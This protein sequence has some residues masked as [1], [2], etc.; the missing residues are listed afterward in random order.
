M[1][2]PVVVSL[3]FDEF[4]EQVRVDA[5]P[6]LTAINSGINPENLVGSFLVRPLIGRVIQD[7]VAN[8]P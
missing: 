2:K 5:A 7:L 8:R 4:V 6:Y 3:T 1:E